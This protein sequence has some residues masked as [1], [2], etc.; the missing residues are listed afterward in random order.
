MAYFRG[1]TIEMK[2]FHLP[3]PDQT[4]THLRAEAERAQVP[5]TALAREAIDMWLQQRLRKARHDAITV[6]AAEVAG[7]ELD[8]DTA[9]EAAG[10]DHLV[11]TG[12]ARK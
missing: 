8:L 3:L 7:T 5:A 4:Y 9:L 10:I 2:N 1:G 11:K 6:Y 12:K